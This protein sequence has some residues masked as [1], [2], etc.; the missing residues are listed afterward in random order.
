MAKSNNINTILLIVL[1]IVVIVFAYAFFTYYPSWIQNRK[2]TIVETEYEQPE[3]DSCVDYDIAN[4]FREQYGSAE[5]NTVMRLCENTL[6][7]NWT[8]DK[9]ELSCYWDR[10]IGTIDCNQQGIKVMEDYCENGLLARWYCDN[11]I[12][13]IGCLCKTSPPTEWDGDQNGDE[14]DLCEDHWYWEEEDTWD[15]DPYEWCSQFNCESGKTCY[16]KDEWSVA[17]QNFKWI[18]YCKDEE[19]EELTVF[20]TNSMWVG[21]V[22]GISGADEKC[23]VASHYAGLGDNFEAIIS[24]DSMDAKNKIKDGTYVRVDGIKVADNKADLF[25]GT[26]DAPINV[27]ENGNDITTAPVWTGTL[28]DGTNTINYNCNGWTWVSQNGTLG[29]CQSTGSYWLSD[30]VESCEKSGHLYCVET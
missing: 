4:E 28:W 20:V 1:I 29:N 24:D 14:E 10:S 25:D 21:A 17:E 30:I 27:N 6:G 3:F 16:A 22:G 7:G 9:A 19:S 12:A 11:D 13:F 8:E 26:L 5:I 23:S 2:I 18:C 15:R